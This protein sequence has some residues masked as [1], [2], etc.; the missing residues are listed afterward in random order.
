MHSVV[1]TVTIR[2]AANVAVATVKTSNLELLATL[3]DSSNTE[4]QRYHL[5]THF[6]G[7]PCKMTAETTRGSNIQGS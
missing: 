3:F 6:E 2:D 5:S 1:T 4:V 7:E